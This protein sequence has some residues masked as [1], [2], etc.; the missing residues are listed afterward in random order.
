MLNTTNCQF[1]NY[2]SDPSFQVK[3]RVLRGHEGAVKT[4]Q[5]CF[6][7]KKILSASYDKTI[8]LWDF[9]T[10][11]L[12]HK[13]DGGHMQYVSGAKMS[14]CNSR[15]VLYQG[16]TSLSLC[17]FSLPAVV[18]IDDTSIES[19]LHETIAGFYA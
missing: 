2:L 19:I 15:L 17:S 12:I 6:D 13:Y 7:D 9:E 14:P 8:R 4:C 11:A 1:A 5:F 3:I 10:G 16:D 18:N